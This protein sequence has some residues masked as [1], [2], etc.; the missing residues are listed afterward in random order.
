[1]RVTNLAR[2]Q[3]KNMRNEKHEFPRHYYTS[4]AI[5]SRPYK[6]DTRGLMLGIAIMAIA[7]IVFFW[8][9]L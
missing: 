7:F 5:V 9:W 1:M 6:R 4:N 8:G 3:P 2:C